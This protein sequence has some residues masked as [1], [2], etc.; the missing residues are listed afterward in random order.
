MQGV[1]ASIGDALGDAFEA[2][3]QGA[4]DLTRNLQRSDLLRDIGRGAA[5]VGE[6]VK[7]TAVDLSERV[8]NEWDKATHGRPA[9]RDR[10]GRD[11]P[12]EQSGS[13]RMLGN[14]PPGCF[15][16][17]RGYACPMHR[18]R[19]LWRYSQDYRLHVEH[20]VDPSNM[21]Q[22]ATGIAG[23]ASDE[24]PPKSSPRQPPSTS[25][26]GARSTSGFQQGQRSKEE[27]EKLDEAFATLLGMGFDPA[28]I[29]AVLKLHSSVERATNA[30][31][32]DPTAM[33][34]GGSPGAP[35][36]SADVYVGGGGAIRQ[37][38]R[39]AIAAGA[40]TASIGASQRQ[41]P[42]VTSGID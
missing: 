8:G 6:I 3:K 15:C 25:P 13:R 12:S 37:H 10:G 17:M 40:A 34:G 23:E 27:I 26:R 9:R 2:A 5:E 42:V 41:Y 7:E 24:P 16:D 35:R 33:P 21:G 30:L 20:N 32:D 29:N 18:G 1:G 38:R 4:S 22:R 14:M 28:R 39:P 11:Q 36:V 31:L 19:E